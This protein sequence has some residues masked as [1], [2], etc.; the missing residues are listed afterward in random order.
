MCFRLLQSCADPLPLF[1][2]RFFTSE[3]MKSPNHL[4]NP[5]VYRITVSGSGVF[6]ISLC[7]MIGA[8][9]DGAMEGR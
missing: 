1:E 6:S 9:E 4:S 8:T 5:A 7:A 3:T 2:G